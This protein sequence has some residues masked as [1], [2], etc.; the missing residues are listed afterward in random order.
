[1]TN[2]TR[3]D[4]ATVYFCLRLVTPE[5]RVVRIHSRRN[6]QRYTT[7]SRSMT[8]TALRSGV[9]VQRMIESA[10]EALQRRK[11]LDLFRSRIRMADRANR[12]VGI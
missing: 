4:I 1:M 7:S 3:R 10:A 12:A 2:S 9:D 6:R 8:T 5:T 11:S